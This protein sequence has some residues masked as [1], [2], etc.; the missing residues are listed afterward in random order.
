MVS[1]AAGLYVHV[2][3]CVTKC[4]YCD[5]CSVTDAPGREWVAAV[6]G[7]AR[8]EAGRFAGFDTLYLGGGTPSSLPAPLVEELVAGLREEADLA[9]GA[10]LTIEV[11]PDDVTAEQLDCWLGL[12]IDRLSV[13]VQSFDDDELAFLGRRHTSRQTLDALALIRGTGPVSLSL[14]LIYGLPGADVGSLKRNL[15]LALEIEPEHLSCYQLTAAADTPLGRR[16]AAGEVVLPGEDLGRELFLTVHGTLVA[17]GYEHY[18]ISNFARSREL[19]S[20]HNLKY[21]N[22]TKV[23][24]LGPGAHSYL[25]GE[26]WWNVKSVEAYIDAIGSGASARQGSEELTADQL[27]L[28]ELMLGFRTSDGVALETLHEIPSGE[29]ALAVLVDQVL[30]EVRAGRARPTVEGFLVADGLPL[31][32]AV[33]EG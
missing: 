15:E 18:E 21:W 2:P 26:R 3:F 9:V 12:G 14:D 30:L 20:R 23:L 25:N 6:L 31:R 22:H 28:E 19:S 29:A 27:L 1:E 33:G 10:E 17:A 8:A 13:G 4:P 24:G 32:F 7:E 16:V 11:N 5:F